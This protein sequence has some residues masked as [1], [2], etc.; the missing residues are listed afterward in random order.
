MRTILGWKT[1]LVLGMTSLCPLSASAIGSV[2]AGDVTF[3]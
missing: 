3:G 1:A 2:T